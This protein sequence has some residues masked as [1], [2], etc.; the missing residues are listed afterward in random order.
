MPVGWAAA[1]EPVG[2]AD[3]GCGAAVVGEEAPEQM[4]QHEAGPQAPHS[5]ETDG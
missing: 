1:E 4:Q 3:G 5:S 2:V